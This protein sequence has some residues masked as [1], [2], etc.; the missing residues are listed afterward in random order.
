MQ[1]LTHTHTV[2]RIKEDD[3]CAK[4]STVLIFNL[5]ANTISTQTNVRKKVQS[6]EKSGQTFTIDR[7]ENLKN[8]MRGSASANSLFGIMMEV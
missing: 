6:R 3:Q 4:T 1:N 7:K 5:H 2:L 8:R